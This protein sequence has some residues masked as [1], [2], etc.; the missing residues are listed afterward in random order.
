[1]WEWGTDG[2]WVVKTFECENEAK[3]S[4]ELQHEAWLSGC[5]PEVCQEAGIFRIWCA[6]DTAEYRRW[7]NKW[8]WAHLSQRVDT[9]HH[10]EC[11]DECTD[12]DEE[13]KDLRDRLRNAGISTR[14]LHCGNVGLMPDGTLVRIDFGEQST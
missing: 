3:S 2:E 11:D 4:M 5:A 6:E 1:M 9:D 14:D 7:T 13:W 10:V 8:R 12:A